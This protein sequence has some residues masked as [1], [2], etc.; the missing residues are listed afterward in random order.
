MTS[1]LGV[2]VQ[3]SGSQS[4]ASGSQDGLYE[5]LLLSNNRQRR[6]RT[7]FTAQQLNEL[8]NLFQRTHYPTFYMREDVSR[9]IR[10]SEARVQNRRA[11]WR[12]H[13]RGQLRAPP[14]QGTPSGGAAVQREPLSRGVPLPAPSPLWRTVKRFPGAGDS[15]WFSDGFRSSAPPIIHDPYAAIAHKRMH[16][17]REI[18]HQ[19]YIYVFA[20]YI[21]LLAV[22]SLPTSVKSQYVLYSPTGVA[23]GRADSLDNADLARFLTDFLPSRDALAYLNG[24]KRSLQN[25]A[26]T[27]APPGFLGARGRRREHLA[28]PPGFVGARG[29]RPSG[30]VPEAY[31]EVFDGPS[32]S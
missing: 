23:S 27:A 5:S 31:S 24:G 13:H 8:E 2:H 32:R 19:Q 16:P 1:S 21:A 17:R 12:K 28:V 29:K 6:N 7:T 18:Y 14:G 26:E 4:H 10:L 20:T 25:A 11:K 15:F 3:S 30:A 22:T 9:R